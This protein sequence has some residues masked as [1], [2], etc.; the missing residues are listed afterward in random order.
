MKRFLTW[1]GMA[2]LG[3]GTAFVILE[4][5]LRATGYSEPV[6]YQPDERLG[7]ALR[8]GA[9]GIYMDEGRALV[10]ISAAGM[11]DRLHPQRKSDNAYRIALLGDGYA[12]AMQVEY[13]D[14]FGFLLEDRLA[15]C[16]FRPGMQVEVLNFGVRG[17]RLAQMLEVFEQR[18]RQYSPD[19]VLVALSSEAGSPDRPVRVVKLEPPWQEILWT[20]ADRLRSV[21]LLHGQYHRMVEEGGLHAST[22]ST[23]KGNPEALL[24][25]LKQA[26]A[27]AGAA[28]VVALIHPQPAVE[29]IG[30]REGIPTI[31]LAEDMR[32]REQAGG[33]P[34]HG[35]ANATLGRGHWNERGH[36]AAA[37]I[38]AASLCTKK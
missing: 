22:A 25:R 26:A 35:F 8:P 20:G 18:A 31:A 38:I 21:Q 3:V 14:T 4:I 5:G 33:A 23:L 28:L 19:L 11:R 12:E 37:D 9:R 30:A 2:I 16:G 13:R 27:D 6:F 1:I 10:R 36:R 24:P 32:R 29:G 17:Y 34:F 7:W 15:R